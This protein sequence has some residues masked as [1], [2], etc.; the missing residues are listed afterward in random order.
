MILL[1]RM[2][3]A[4]LCLMAVW[5]CLGCARADESWTLP[6]DVWQ[7]IPCGEDALAVTN[8][9]VYLLN[10]TEE[11][12][13]LLIM[14]EGAEQE[15]PFYLFAGQDKAVYAL[16][17]RDASWVLCRGTV[18]DYTLALTVVGEMP[19]PWE[20]PGIMELM[21][22]EEGVVAL[23]EGDVFCW[24]PE[25]GQTMAWNG[26]GDQPLM[27]GGGMLLT[28]RE[29]E[30]RS[31]IE[32][33][34]VH[35]A[36]HALSHMVTTEWTQDL[37]ISPDGRTVAWL[38]QT[39]V[40]AWQEGE[41]E[42]KGYLGIASLAKDHPCAVTDGQRFYLADGQRVL[43]VQTIPGFDTSDMGLVVGHTGIDLMLDRVREAHGDLNVFD[44]QLPFGTDP[45]SI[46][47]AIRTGDQSVDIY[48]VRTSYRGYR[49]MLEKGFCADL[50]ESETLMRQVLAMPPSVSDAVM[51]KGRLLA[52]PYAAVFAEGTLGCSQQ[53][54][55]AM[56]LTIED[57]PSS[58]DGLL[59][60]LLVWLDE[61]RMDQVWVSE[62]HEDTSLLY[63]LTVNGYVLCAGRGQ[64]YID[65][66]DPAFRALMKKYDQVV[67]LLESREEPDVN[68]PVL[69][70]MR[71]LDRFLGISPFGEFALP[72]STNRTANWQMLRYSALPGQEQM[73][74][75]AL[76]VAVVN[77]LSKRKE[78]AIAFLEL[79]LEELPAQDAL[80]FWPDQAVPVEKPTYL[81]DTAVLRKEI[82]TYE[83]M[84]ERDDLTTDERVSAENVLADLQGSL[85]QSEGKRWLVSE[86]AIKTYRAVQ[87]ELAVMTNDMMSLIYDAGELSI[88]ERYMEGQAT[89]DQFVDAMGNL[90]W[91]IMQENQ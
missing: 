21:A 33:Y 24:N 61:G 52:I 10:T 11:G 76:D 30:G 88:R 20:Q 42:S 72:W 81:K 1:K 34:Q 25:T 87:E 84:L 15:L 50:S 48:L 14:V 60:A 29:Q 90:S 6:E 2:M 49:A 55:E 39:A 70:S 86:E 36:T 64:A 77:P 8:N 5:G 35:L 79:M 45:A 80:C 85:A 68:A 31:E 65:L 23:Y 37:A 74:G 19:L 16:L 59:D 51:S 40:T 27:A 57:M 28:C 46:A 32:I 22:C 89:V 73:I 91:S 3:I 4:C 71:G 43:S 82:G 41:E 18:Q 75:V 78:E 54:L 47:Q 62:S 7:V 13:A 12:H 9:A 38:H 17:R 56:G 66:R 44:R 67:K 83:A 63:G 69:F 58:V 53:A 26:W